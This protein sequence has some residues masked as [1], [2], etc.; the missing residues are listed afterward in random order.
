M[1]VDTKIRENSTIS[2]LSI[3]KR[4]PE[5]KGEGD[6]SS[7]NLGLQPINLKAKRFAFLI[8]Y[9]ECQH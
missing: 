8:H 9:R 7:L 1:D 2:T 3:A 6:I 5:G 4:D